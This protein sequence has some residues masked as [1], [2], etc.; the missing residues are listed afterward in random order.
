MC[1]QIVKVLFAVQS[2]GEATKMMVLTLVAAVTTAP[3]G[4]TTPCQAPAHQECTRL[5]SLVPGRT[6]NETMLLTRGVLAFVGLLE[7]TSATL[8]CRWT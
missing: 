1:G 6:G 4:V 2:S 8:N 7:Q 3:M 5:V